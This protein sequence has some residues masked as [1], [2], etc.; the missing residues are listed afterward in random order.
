MH[1]KEKW[2][3]YKRIYIID[4]WRDWWVMEYRQTDQIKFREDLYPRF[5]YDPF[6]VQQYAANLEMLPAIKINQHNELIDGYHR[7]TAYK[8]TEVE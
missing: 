5:K 6:L 3:Y 4:G 1:Q 8:T 7:L 2:M